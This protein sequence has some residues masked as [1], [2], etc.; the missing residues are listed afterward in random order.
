MTKL[1]FK[2]VFIL[3]KIKKFCNL[4]DL[5]IDSVIKKAT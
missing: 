4:M 2:V 3:E 5:F 1:D